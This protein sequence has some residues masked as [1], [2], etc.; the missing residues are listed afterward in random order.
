MRGLGGVVGVGREKWMLEIAGWGW[1]GR[2]EVKGDEGEGTREKDA[3]GCAD[4]GVGV[5]EG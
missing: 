5:K 1:E 3:D 4:G 2:E